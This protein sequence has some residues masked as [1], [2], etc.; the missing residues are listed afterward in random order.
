MR[1]EQ[2]FPQMRV[3]GWMQPAGQTERGP[4]VPHT[5]AGRCGFGVPLKF[6]FPQN[7]A[8]D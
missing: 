8:E 7:C 2:P 6:M 5:A 4:R 3:V 1:P